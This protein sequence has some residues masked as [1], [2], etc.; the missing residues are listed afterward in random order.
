[1][2]SLFKPFTDHPHEVGETYFQHLK[3]AATFGLSMF[4]GSLACFTH[5]VFPFLFTKTG[6]NKINQLHWRMHQ[7][8]RLETQSKAQDQTAPNPHERFAFAVYSEL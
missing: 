4:V 3:V 8:R 5:A 2:K 1:M 6:R 7:G